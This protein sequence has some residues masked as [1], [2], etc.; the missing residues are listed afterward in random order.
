MK[1][2]L[3]ERLAQSDD[4]LL[5]YAPLHSLLAD[6][7]MPLEVHL[8]EWIVTHPDAYQDAIAR[9][10][11]AGCDFAHTATQAASPFRSVVYGMQHKVREHNLLS[12]Q[13]ARA[14]TPPDRFLLGHV[15]TSNPD[16]LEPVGGMTRT[17]VF[18]GYSRQI[19]PLLEGG[20]D[21]LLIAGNHLEETVVAIEAARKLSGA[22]IVAQNVFY[23]GRRGYRT[24]MGHD[25]RTAT[26][27][28][29]EA[30]ADV[31]GASCGLMLESGGAPGETHYYEA[32]TRL[33]DEMRAA[34]PGMLSLQPNAGMARLVEG[35]TVYPALPEE[36]AAE[37]ARWVAAGA[38]IIGGCCGTSLK[39][40]EALA[41]S[42][43][44][45]R[46]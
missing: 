41:R 45:A 19:E 3:L 46:N 34:G 23:A 29:R 36:L 32:A 25:V 24:L 30:G 8:S 22:P 27:R 14:V 43:R 11:E 7:G 10:F 37:A 4:V 18:E 17:F 15:S 44:R 12:A 26:L 20:V 35:M 1:E 5:H 28:L 6:W 39:H 31:A 16:F 13:L 40:Y 21:C 33:L 9:S 2:P 38:R 42:V